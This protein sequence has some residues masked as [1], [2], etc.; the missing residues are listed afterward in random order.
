MKNVIINRDEWFPYYD[1]Q[2]SN[3]LEDISAH[4]KL[5][6]MTDEEYVMYKG[7][8]LQME[9]LQRKL[10]ERWNMVSFTKEQKERQRNWA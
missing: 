3:G 4:D 7:L 9:K 6:I 1:L 10:D 2:E 5:C 8:L